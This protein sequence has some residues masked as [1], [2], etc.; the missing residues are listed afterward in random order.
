MT[1]YTSLLPQDFP[2]G[3]SI[4]AY[5]SIPSTNTALKEMAAAGAPEG[6][7]IIAEHQSAGRGR[8]GRSF[9]SP[10]GQGLYLSLLLRPGCKPEQLMHLTC[11]AGVAACDAVQA[12]TQL[13]PGIKWANDLVVGK[14][15]LGGILT[16]MGFDSLGN[17]AW[18]VI[19][20][21][22][23]CAQLP[24]DFPEEIRPIATSLAMAVGKEVD[25]HV[26]AARLLEALEKMNRELL[27][28][29]PVM[30][31]YRRDCVTLGQPISIHRY[32]SVTH[33]IAL[34]VEDEGALTVQLS[35]GS[36]ESVATGEVSIRGMYGYV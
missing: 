24:E 34:A 9:S 12:L 20:I 17:C 23:N 3:K 31:R 21:G 30:A 26:L 8:M 28:P 15:K 16:E 18:V 6:T 33:G 32:D 14:R 36:R 5:A 19:G 1:D 29:G 13:R 27:S 10:R 35:D 25:R 7:V 11:A 2:W 4:H 22:I